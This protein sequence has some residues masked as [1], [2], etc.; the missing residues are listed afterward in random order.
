[1]RIVLSSTGKTIN[2]KIDLQFGRCPFFIIV[3][4]E[5]KK[6][7]K[8]DFLKNNFANQSGGVGIIIAQKIVELETS[9]LI[10]GNVGPRAM[11]IL[12]QFKIPIF[13]GEG[14]IKDEI[15]NFLKNKLKPI[16]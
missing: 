12:K 2:D 11:D 7:V 14:M 15:N 5:E 1:M 10:T 9:V 3:E 4:V 16:N 8:T 13:R 6:I